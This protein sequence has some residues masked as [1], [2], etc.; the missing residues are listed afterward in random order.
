ME[1]EKTNLLGLERA[2]LEKFF[3]TLG[4]KP[5]RAQ[6][7]LRWAYHQ[8]VTDFGEMT[9]L[10]RKLRDALSSIAE[11]H[12]PEIVK[13]YDSIDGTKKWIVRAENGNSVET[14]LIPDRG[15]N[16]LCISSQVGCVL[17]CRFCATGKQGFNGNLSRADIAGQVFNVARHL[18]SV[19][20]GRGI[21]NVVF[22]GMGEPL[23][24]FESVMG[25]VDLLTDDLAFGISKRRVTVSTAG[26]APEI[27][28]MADRTGAALAVSLH[29]ATDDLRDDLVPLNKK[30][31]IAV[32]LDACRYYLSKVGPRRS[33]TIEYA[34]LA[35]VNDSILHA[36]TLAKVLR[37][38]RCKINL[39]PFNPF[40]ASGFERPDENTVREFQ[41]HLL[42]AGY[43]TMVRTTR[44][45]DIEAACGQLVGEVQDRTRRKA[46]YIARVQAQEVA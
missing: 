37:T 42:N 12:P 27:C 25:V 34:L 11:F 10:S 20:D 32:L 7:I 13:R 46:R 33:V 31:P 1:R 6:Q 3:A 19:G 14:V 17:D 24:N 26:V 44:G 45:E 28:R 41:T 16:T 43:A 39:I 30:Y 15:R 18:E 40:P 22:M 9:N 29:A 8:G 2:E 38:I 5:Y 36:K 23:Y 4:E 35:G 21:T